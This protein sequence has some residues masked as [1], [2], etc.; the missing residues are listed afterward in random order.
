MS[1]L[2]AGDFD[3]IFG[4]D[5]LLEESEIVDSVKDLRSQAP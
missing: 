3:P 4:D 1:E 2:S 5:E